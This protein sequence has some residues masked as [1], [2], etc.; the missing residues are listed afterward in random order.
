MHT[1]IWHRYQSQC[2]T[3]FRSYFYS[4]DFLKQCCL[5]ILKDP[6]TTA[7]PHIAVLVKYCCFRKW[8]QTIEEKQLARQSLKIVSSQ[9]QMMPEGWDFL[10]WESLQTVLH[11]SS[12]II[13]GCEFESPVCILLSFFYLFLLFPPIYTLFPIGCFS[14]YEQKINTF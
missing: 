3:K 11:K 4:H 1:C 13:W 12:G 10:C 8:T 7:T 2:E 6:I 5:I 9:P 14:F